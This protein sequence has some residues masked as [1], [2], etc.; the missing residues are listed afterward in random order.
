[1]VAKTLDL[2][3]TNTLAYVLG[4]SLTMKKSFQ[5]FHQLIEYFEEPDRFYLVFEKVNGGKK[6]IQLFLIKRASLTLVGIGVK[7]K[8]LRSRNVECV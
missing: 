1:M 2:P 3:V 5:C 8:V 6:T 7:S 4:S